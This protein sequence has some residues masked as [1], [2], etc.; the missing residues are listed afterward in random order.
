LSALLDPAINADLPDDEARKIIE[1]GFIDA[2]K[3]NLSLNKT[4]FERFYI[5]WSNLYDP[6]NRKWKPWKIGNCILAYDDA[7]Y[8]SLIDNFKKLGFFEDADSCYYYY[9]MKRRGDLPKA[10]HPFDLLL[11]LI[12]EYGVKP[13]R[14]LMGIVF[15]LLAFGAMYSHFGVVGNSTLDAFNTSLIVSLSGTKLIEDP[16]HPQHG[17]YTG[18]SHWRSYSHHYFSRCF[19][20]L[21]VGR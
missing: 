3:R 15:L 2:E 4:K 20:F 12:Y 18:H 10:Y 9:R 1:E 13:L 6:L 7:T 16:N 17:C 5:R 11:W 21:L 19:S 14:P 8:L